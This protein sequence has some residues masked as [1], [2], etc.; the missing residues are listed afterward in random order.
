MTTNPQAEL[1]RKM[2]AEYD[3]AIRFFQP[4]YDD[5]LRLSTDLAAANAPTR[6]MCLDYGAGT[7]GALPH[8]ASLFDEVVAVDP[9]EAMLDLA[10]ARVGG[11]GELGRVR[12][13]EGT[14]VSAEVTSLEDGSFD[15]IHCSLVSMFLKGDDAKL[16]LFG[17]FRRLLK[18]DGVL[19][20]TDLFVEPAEDST[21][22][23]WRT[24][25]QLRGAPE[26]TIA[27]GVAQV[28]S[29]MDRRSSHE[30]RELLHASGF[31]KVVHAYQALH[32]GVFVAGR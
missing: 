6:A 14:C 5:M 22:A 28:Y 4:T 2:A 31:E 12:F 19:V 29:H 9:A 25:M 30:T 17:S 26:E 3:A 16:E 15:A 23:L 13:I 7:G 24:L 32:T 20:L 11:Q 21:F 18:A 10:R 1:F 27:K 8:L